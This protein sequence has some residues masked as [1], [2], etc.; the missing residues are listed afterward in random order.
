MLTS[1]QCP[2]KTEGGGGGP[3]ACRN[4]GSEDHIAK[5]CDQPRNPATITCR[6]CEQMGH[7]SRECPEPRDYS[8]VQCSNCQECKFF[9]V[10]TLSFSTLIKFQSDT[11]RSDARR[12]SLTRTLVAAT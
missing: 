11:Q 8:K 10:T 5:E 1:P 12:L 2:E 3:R 4:C 6:N 7:M 9:L